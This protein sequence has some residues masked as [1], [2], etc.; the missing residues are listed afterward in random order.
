MSSNLHDVLAPKDVLN[1][2]TF[3]YFD[4]ERT[5]H[6]LSQKRV[7]RTNGDILVFIL[8]CLFNKIVRQFSKCVWK[9]FCHSDSM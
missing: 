3:Q 5:R 9:P 8:M 6:R 4:F 2:L 1:Y 7:V